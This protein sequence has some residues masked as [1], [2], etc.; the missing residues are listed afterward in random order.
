ML[1]KILISCTLF[2]FNASTLAAQETLDLRFLSTSD[3]HSY[4]SQY[5]YYNE[6]YSQSYG[7]VGLIG[8]I[9][10][11]RSQVKNSFLVDTGDTLVG[12]PLGNFIAQS[13]KPT[14]TSWQSAII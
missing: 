10:Y 3:L 6:S 9:D 8:E 2:S 14:D 4:I 7:L 11:Y 12:N 13:F 5:D 1:R